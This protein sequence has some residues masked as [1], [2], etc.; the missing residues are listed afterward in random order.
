MPIG[1]AAM[2]PTKHNN[3]GYETVPQSGLGGRRGY[4]PRGKTLGGSSS[5]NAMMYVRG[6]RTDY[7]LWSNEGNKG[8]SFQECLP[9]FKKSENN[10]VFS[11]EYHG[12]GGPLNVTNLGSPSVLVDRFL[13]ACESIGIPRNDDINGANQ[14]GAMMSQV[15]QINGERCSAA[16]AYLSPCLGRKNLTILTNAT[17]HKVIFDGK[18]AIGV[19]FGHKRRTHQ[20]YA[21]KEVL[22]SAGAF[23]SPQILLLSG[24]G[25][26]EQFDRFGI[27]KV[28][29]LK[30]VGENLQDHIDLVHAFR[31]KEK[32]DTFGISLSMVKKLARAWPDWR[33]RRSGK[34]SSNFA[35]GVAFLFSDTKSKVPDLEFVFVI[36]MV[37]DH[38]RKVRYGHGIS[39]HVTLLRPKSRGSV[40]L[41]SIDPYSPPEIDPNFFSHP[42]DMST[43]IKAW[44]KQYSMLMSARFSDILAESL[45]P[46]DPDDDLAIEK[47]IRR[48][49]DTQYH[50]VGTCKMGPSND[51]MAVVNNRL[52][53]Y[54]VTVLRVIDASIMPSLIGG[55]TNAPT[56]M[57]AEKAADMI[58]EEHQIEKEPM[59]K[60][61]KST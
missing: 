9:Y 25:P 6:N 61:R 8:W 15:T 49:A 20:I 60:L 37:D 56:I 58:K 44:K 36:A 16:K 21:K 30:G 2:V 32:H 24:V 39:S 47:D 50:P 57:I 23:A 38:A 5:I 17:T 29:H 46:V 14:F 45:Y 52:C 48:R 43:M 19:E 53:V 31:T 10:E 42:D 4:Q 54:G 1:T 22:L 55:N 35:E 26:E 11:D 51:E 40:R 7:D 18:R 3:W 59:E 33:N 41:N 28:H 13:D 27:K 12:K 34:M